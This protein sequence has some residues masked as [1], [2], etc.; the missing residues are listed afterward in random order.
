MI[1]DTI[2]TGRQH[3]YPHIINY[4][5]CSIDSERNGLL[6]NELTCEV[7]IIAVDSVPLGPFQSYYPYRI[8]KDMKRWMQP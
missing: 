2:S 4:L 8:E 7:M 1:A 6:Y 3:R 5:L